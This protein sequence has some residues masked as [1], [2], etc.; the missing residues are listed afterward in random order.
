MIIDSKNSP[1]Y[2]SYEKN[3]Y[4]GLFYSLVRVYQPTKVVEL[5]T[6]AGYSA[7]HIA[8]GLKDNGKGVID[9]YDLWENYDFN[10]V[11]QSV[12]EKNL[13]EFKDIVNFKLGDVIGLEKKY[14]AIDM[15]HIDLGN[16][17][18]ILEKIIPRWINKTRLI[19][20]EGGSLERDRVEWMIKFNK[21]P[22]KKWLADFTKKR[23]DIEY[24]TMELFPSVTIICKVESRN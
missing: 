22:I 20:I 21:I 11:P 12:A 15:L 23:G 14:K 17:G 9:C 13:T 3:N 6:K 5:G 18:I 1:W 19:V 7:Y 16:D 8:R 2:S 24:S 10:S 4:G